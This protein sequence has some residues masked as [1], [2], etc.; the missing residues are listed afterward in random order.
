VDPSSPAADPKPLLAA[1]N[2]A[3]E[4]VAALHIV[5]LAVCAYV[6]VIVF[7][8]TDTDLLIGKGVKLPVVDVE[9]P[10]V[11]FYILSPYLLVLVHFNL[12]L[13]LQLLSRKLYA[14]DEAVAGGD[15]A[16]GLHDQ[17]NIFPYNYYLIGRPNRLVRGSLALAVTIT[18]LFLPLAALLTLQARFLAYQN[19][20]VTWAQRV[21]TWL[22]VT[23][24]VALWPVIMDRRDSWSGYFSSVCR[25]ARLHWIRWLWGLAGLVIVVALLETRISVPPISPLAPGVTP[26]ATI[27]A[28]VSKLWL[29][30][31]LA[32]WL[33]LTIVTPILRYGV[34][35]LRPGSDVGSPNLLLGV[36]GLLTIILI[37]LPLPLLLVANGERLDRP[38]AVAI[39]LLA[40]LRSLDVH[41]KVLLAKPASPETL[42]D[43]RGEDP[44]RRQEALRSVQRLDLQNRSLRRANLSHALLP[45]AD[46]R[47]A[48]LQGAFLLGAQLQGVDL[49]GATL[50][51]VV[52]NETQ[53]QGA[54][55]T[56]AH[57][58]RTTFVETWLDGAQFTETDL[59]GA[60]FSEVQLQGADL[61]GAQLTNKNLSETALRGANLSRAQLSGA[62]LSG[63]L[64]QSANLSNAHLQGANLSRAQ[65]E[66]ADLSNAKLPGARLSDADLQAATLSNA[67]LHGADLSG[68]RLQGANLSA[69]ELTAADLSR[70]QLQGANLS[71]ARLE[72]ANLSGA[73]LQGTNLSNAS[74]AAASLK[75]AVLY[76]E[77]RTAWPVDARGLKWQPIEAKEL[78]RLR[79]EQA[80]FPWRKKDD[81]ARYGA[82][83]EKAAGPGVKPPEIESCLR[84]SNT[85]V[86]CKES[87]STAQFRA[88]L[89]PTLEALACQ[90][91]EIA[92]GV[93][94][95]FEP[96][97][98]DGEGSPTQDLAL[99]L[100][101]I[102][103]KPPADNSC[104]GLAGLS[105]EDKDL[106]A[107]LAARD[108]APVGG[109][110]KTTAPR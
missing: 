91:P 100:Q 17:L 57:F 80:G 14:F 22:D 59:G 82:A 2:S 58:L 3:S 32:L 95:R 67:E 105:R 16:G 51:D 68:A 27:V 47:A 102:V 38:N 29:L 81:L 24:V 93:F 19:E 33:L 20:A 36:P 28:K 74:L 106:L 1:A 65:L 86:P 69:A 77:W 79:E 94:R 37:G 84:D 101:T 55:F 63:V 104:P 103:T 40:S 15:G 96:S 61:S 76:T 12:L 97:T 5:F 110:S 85:Q 4:K 53:L 60:I 87:L 42:A 8:T 18:I 39:E 31:L 108:E 45:R 11:G 75:G 98:R 13:S 89:L 7:G 109:A 6:L 62:I 50:Q 10:I 70:A 78:A 9:V 64:L 46:L 56:K 88:S 23:L 48:Q 90:S 92:R 21:A 30:K 44:A 83:I 99:R 72:G 73:L 35:R 41:E 71:Y 52:F 25:H 34:R 54:N 66:G 26:V 107:G 43:L 49:T